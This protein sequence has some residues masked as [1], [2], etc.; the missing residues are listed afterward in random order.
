MTKNEVALKFMEDYL[1]M[2]R[3]IKI[4]ELQLEMQALPDIVTT[5]YPIMF[6]D[7]EIKLNYE[8]KS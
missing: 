7:F 4:L 8:L 1:E 3:K 2:E 6:D 5:E